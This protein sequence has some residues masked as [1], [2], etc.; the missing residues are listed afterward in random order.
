MGLK[1]E[2]NIINYF[3]ILVVYIWNVKMTFVTVTLRHLWYLFWNLTK[4]S[5]PPIDNNAIYKT[6]LLWVCFIS[7]HTL[8]GNL[9]RLLNSLETSV[10][11]ECAWIIILGITIGNRDSSWARVYLLSL[12]ALRISRKWFFLFKAAKRIW[13]NLIN[14]AKSH[15]CNRKV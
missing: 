10:I 6:Y 1:T 8:N 7:Y 15:N 11:L 12:V 13:A 4:I 9:E 2:M 3:V 5:S 14:Y